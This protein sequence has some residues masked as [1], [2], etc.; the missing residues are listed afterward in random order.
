MI[1]WG[2]LSLGLLSELLPFFFLFFFFFASPFFPLL[3][4]LDFPPF[5]GKGCYLAVYFSLS[6]LWLSL[7][8]SLFWDVLLLLFG[9]FV[10][11]IFYFIETIQVVFH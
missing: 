3:F 10:V 1:G 11:V 5:L 7:T 6:T 4:L 9:F 8:A 2:V